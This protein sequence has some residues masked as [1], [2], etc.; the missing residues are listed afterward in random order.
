MS[1]PSPPLSLAPLRRVID[2]ITYHPNIYYIDLS[3]YDTGAGG[4][5]GIDHNQN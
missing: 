4:D 1:P 3:I 5:N 2:S